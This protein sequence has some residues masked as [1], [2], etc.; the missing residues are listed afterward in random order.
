[1]TLSRSTLSRIDSRIRSQLD[2]EEGVQLVKVPVSE[3]VWATWRRYCEAAGI[4]MGRALSILM[5]RELASVV[6]ENLDGVAEVLTRRVRE[7]NER[8]AALDRR[9]QELEQRES[10]IPVAASVARRPTSAT[11]SRR[12]PVAMTRVGR[13]DP[14]PCGSGS[15]YKLATA[16][17]NQDSR[18]RTSC[19]SRRRRGRRGPSAGITSG[20]LSPSTVSRPPHSFSNAARGTRKVFPKEITGRPSLPSVARHCRAKLYA[21][22]RPM[23][24]TRA[25]SSTVKKS[26]GVDLFRLIPPCHIVEGRQLRRYPAVVQHG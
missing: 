10:Q 2:H 5:H 23:R 1:M 6:D 15:K 12:L 22:P 4:P 13:N 18:G 3:A 20:S 21:A 9:E 17:K 7:L 26:G 16:P 19:C 8:E 24:R 11:R 25:A 14:C